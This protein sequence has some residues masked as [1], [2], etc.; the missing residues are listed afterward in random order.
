MRLW[1]KDLICVLPRQ[2]LLGQWRELCAI[3]RSIEEKG[4]PNHMLVNQIMDYEPEHLH[5]YAALVID[6]ISRRGYRCNSA[7]FTSPYRRVC[8]SP[9]HNVKVKDLFDIWMSDRYLNQCYYNL[10]EKFD[11]GGISCEEWQRIET[12]YRKLTQ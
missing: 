5:S 11:C 4:T 7:K 12:S 1:H 8:G 2:Q 10:Q 9:S 6:E 3:M